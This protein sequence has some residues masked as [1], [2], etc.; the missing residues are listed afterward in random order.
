M[1]KEMLQQEVNSFFS[2]NR[3]T[4]VD[5][6]T[7]AMIQYLEGEYPQD[8][9]PDFIYISFLRSSV[10]DDSPIYRIDFYNEEERLDLRGYRKYW[11]VPELSKFIER[12]L[13]VIDSGKPSNIVLKHIIQNERQKIDITEQFNIEFSNYITSSF[14]KD[15][16]KKERILMDIEIFIGDFM[17]PVHSTE[18]NDNYGS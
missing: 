10:L 4:I 18:R 2:E 7:T 14:A 17:G 12:S 13:E 9:P 11:D 8:T 16:S 15:M 3:K 6:L 5:D 1:K